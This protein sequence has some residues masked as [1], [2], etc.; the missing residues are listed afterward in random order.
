MYAVF[1]EYLW[2]ATIRANVRG[3]STAY[4]LLLNDRVSAG[5]IGDAISWDRDIRM[6]LGIDLK[7]HILTF[8]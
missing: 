6:G 7:R 5:G 4:S 8:M 2:V 1:Y 3:F